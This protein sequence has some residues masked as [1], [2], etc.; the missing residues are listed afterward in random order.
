MSIIFSDTFLGVGALRGSQPQVRFRPDDLPYQSVLSP[1]NPEWTHQRSPEGLQNPKNT[2]EATYGQFGFYVQYESNGTATRVDDVPLA[3][4]DAWVPES[5]EWEAT[6]DMRTDY[7]HQGESFFGA[8]LELGSASSGVVRVE[9]QASQSKW[10]FTAYHPSANTF[11]RT[12]MPEA[13][14]LGFH[15]LRLTHSRTKL[16]MEGAGGAFE[17][18]YPEIL[19]ERGFDTV[20]VHLVQKP[21]MGIRNLVVKRL[22]APATFWTGFAKTVEA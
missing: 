14:A 1:D 15:A 17:L 2:N 21:G 19:G 8:F 12:E 22:G 6:F 16:S 20:K 3:E 4:S 7:V 11:G 10:F 9:I 13:M 18:P 5:T